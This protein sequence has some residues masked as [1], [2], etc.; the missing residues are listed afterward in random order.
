MIILGKIY[1]FSAFHCQY[2]RTL[3][4]SNDSVKSF[5]VHIQC[6]RCYKLKWFYIIQIELVSNVLGFIFISLLYILF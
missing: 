3:H 4:I 5:F 1:T 6:T 2:P